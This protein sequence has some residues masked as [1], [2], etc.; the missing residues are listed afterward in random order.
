M[1]E[2]SSSGHVDATPASG[3]WLDPATRW[4]LAG[5]HVGSGALPV[6]P[7]APWRSHRGSTARPVM[8]RAGGCAVVLCLLGLAT[9]A[10]VGAATTGPG[11]TLAGGAFSGTAPGGTSLFEYTVIR[12]SADG[13]T[14]HFHGDWTASCKDGSARLISFDQDNVAIDGSTGQFQVSGQ[15]RSSET[16]Q[17]SGKISADRASATGS[18]QAAV[19]GSG[20]SEQ[21]SASVGSWTVSSGAGKGLTAP[22][23][24]GPTLVGP[25]SAGL[26]L[27]MKVK[28]G[29]KTIGA[30]G[31]ESNVFCAKH[32][33]NDV[34]NFI[35]LNS[36]ISKDGTFVANQTLKVSGYLDQL[37]FNSPDAPARITSTFRGRVDSRGA[38][39][40]WLL[41]VNVYG[42]SG[43]LL[44]TC[45]STKGPPPSNS[46]TAGSPVGPVTFLAH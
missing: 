17:V 25:T 5:Q 21:C 22:L 42:S 15:T 6:T 32:T 39:G 23:A 36:S 11:T 43:A 34:V 3:G 44:D 4:C 19:S 2:E 38:S 41:T 1:A 35:A 9:P 37:G 29:G 45:T 18:G 16:F 28:P 30:V 7:P 26:P 33:V 24:T 8:R 46:Y 20:A 10:T 12:F 13:A 40:S 27:I 31:A 14:L